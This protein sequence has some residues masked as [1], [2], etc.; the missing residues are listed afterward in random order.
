M[1]M[2]QSEREWGKTGT[3]DETIWIDMTF[4]MVR[5]KTAVGTEGNMWAWRKICDKQCL[6]RSILLPQMGNQS[7]RQA[8]QWRTARRMSCDSEGKRKRILLFRS[9]EMCVVMRRFYLL[10]ASRSHLVIVHYIVA[11]HYPFSSHLQHRGNNTGKHNVLHRLCI[12]FSL[13]K[14]HHDS[15]AASTWDI[16]GCL[17]GPCITIHAQM[18]KKYI[19]NGLDGPWVCARRCILKS[20]SRTC[21]DALVANVTATEKWSS[22][23][24]RHMRK[25]TDIQITAGTDHCDVTMPRTHHGIFIEG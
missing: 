3:S 2:N 9:N 11:Q 4:W 22:H 6:D 13:K 14:Q 15:A 5:T 23:C 19:F 24:Q 12:P 8:A 18:L 17:H 16:V 25:L 1:L 7:E 10:K 20:L 21:L